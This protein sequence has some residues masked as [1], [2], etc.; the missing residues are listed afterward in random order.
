MTKAEKNLISLK[1]GKVVGWRELVGLPDLNIEQL[2]AKID[3]G[4]RTSAIHAEDQERFDHEGENWV[5]FRIPSARRKQD[6]IFEAPVFDEREIKN[7]GGLPERRIIIRTT[8]LL[9]A[10]RTHIDVSLADRKAMEFDLILGRT[11]I[12]Q[13]RLIIHP[14]RSFLMGPPKPK[15]TRKT[16]AIQ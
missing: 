14:G 11:A 1:S 9:G 13:L 2:R 4:A 8:L 5:R 10:H 15:S 7:T 3:S 16:A 12:R 6:Q